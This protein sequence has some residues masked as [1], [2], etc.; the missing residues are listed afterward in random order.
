MWR[1]T[2]V[3]FTFRF[4]QNGCGYSDTTTMHYAQR[5]SLQSCNVSDLNWWISQAL[6]SCCCAST[7]CRPILRSVQWLANRVLGE[8]KTPL[9]LVDPSESTVILNWQSKR[10]CAKFVSL[11]DGIFLS[12]FS[13]TAW[14]DCFCQTRNMALRVPKFR[15]V[16]A[17]EF[18]SSQSVDIWIA[19]CCITSLQSDFRRSRHV[20]SL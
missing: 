14:F 3:H 10:Q 4:T 17:Q 11:E 6:M 16:F 9:G 18:G 15:L 5:K 1:Y 2:A 13:Y 20:L 12:R 19:S 7:S 8:K